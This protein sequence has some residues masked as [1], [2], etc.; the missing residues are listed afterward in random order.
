LYRRTGQIFRGCHV[1]GE[2]KQGMTPFRKR[3]G[4]GKTDAGT[5]SG[6]N[7]ERSGFAHHPR[8]RDDVR[9]ASLTAVA[10][11]GLRPVRRRCQPG[12]LRGFEK[13]PASGALRQVVA[14]ASQKIESGCVPGGLG[15]PA[16]A[17]AGVVEPVAAGVVPAEPVDGVPAVAAAEDL[18]EADARGE[19]AEPVEAAVRGEPAEPVEAA[20]RG[21]PAELVGAAVRGE[22]GVAPVVVAAG[23]EPEWEWRVAGLEEKPV[24]DPACPTGCLFALEMGE[25]FRCSPL[26]LQSKELGVEEVGR[27]LRRDA[28]GLP[29]TEEFGYLEAGR[30]AHRRSEDGFGVALSGVE[31]PAVSPGRLPRRPG[32][33]R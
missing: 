33:F 1:P 15:E 14:G 28:G 25:E 30:R 22:P 26:G 24:A 2:K 17:F 20:V 7:D 6:D 11:A 5:G 29:S 9:A 19:P 10:G 21:E 3:A 16:G 12:R 27:S 32:G 8:L 23:T 13:E 31:C 18:V 4:N